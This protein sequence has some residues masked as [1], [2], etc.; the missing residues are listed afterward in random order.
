VGVRAIVRRW[1]V[2]CEFSIRRWDDRG[3]QLGEYATANPLMTTNRHSEWTIYDAKRGKPP[4]SWYATV[5]ADLEDQ[6]DKAFYV[7]K[8]NA[9][10]WMVMS[11]NVYHCMQRLKRAPSVQFRAV[12]PGYQPASV[13]A[14][15]KSTVLHDPR[16]AVSVIHAE[17]VSPASRG[18]R[19]PAGQG[20]LCT[21]TERI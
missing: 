15:A 16:G 5:N 20:I 19:R 10:S 21:Q 8:R 17:C 11:P 12:Y 18:F 3:C 4:Q 1:V 14:D 7:L 2:Y 13:T 9:F 6:P